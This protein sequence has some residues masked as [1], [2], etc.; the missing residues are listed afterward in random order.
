MGSF[1]RDFRR[2]SAVAWLCFL[3][4]G[5]TGEA[6]E[7]EGGALSTAAQAL[8]EG[9]ALSPHDASC[10]QLTDQ[11]TWSTYASYMAAVPNARALSDVLADLNRAGPVLTASTHP[12]AVG[13]KGGFRWNDGDMAATEWV[14]QGMTAGTSGSQNVVIAAWQ[15]ALSPDKGVRISVADV[16]DMSGAAVNYRHLLLVRPT[17]SGNFTLVPEHGGGLAWVGNYLF[18]ADTADGI[19]VFDLTQ[20]R[21]VDTSAACESA[22]G[23][24]TTPSGTVWCAYGYK[25]VLPQASAYVV[26]ASITSPCRPTF[27]FLG[28]DTRGTAPVIL[29]G[30]YCNDGDTPCP[31][32]GSTPGLGGRLYRWPLDSTT[33]RLK[34]V[35]GIVKPEKA[36][37]MN[38]PNVQ[39]VAPI[40]TSTATTS[41]WLSSTR[42][43][44]A[45]FKVSTTAARTMYR[46]TDGQ[47]AR[48]PEGMHATGTGTN[49]WTVTEG[50][51]GTTNPASG[52]RIVFF[53]DQAS[54][55]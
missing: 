5:P 41:Y 29:T 48:M 15:Y 51:N 22:I 34:T 17:A 54:V 11:N 9:S 18:M 32:D 43:T 14:P 2:V 44:G 24:T 40:M 50:Y 21:E 16:S 7:R 46:A 27:S 33:S 6:G 23:K 35:G 4:C 19:R 38:E 36:Y 39:G 25:Y 12:P 3:G 30:E 8:T 20:I 10:L 52:G 31:Y 13:Y 26:P 49:L 37:L 53:V 28:K 1:T 45:L 42:Y 47:W 55:D